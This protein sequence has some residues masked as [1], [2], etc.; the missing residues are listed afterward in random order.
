MDQK[1]VTVDE[2]GPATVDEVGPVP[3]TTISQP[4]PG[5]GRRSRAGAHQDSSLVGEADEMVK[6]PA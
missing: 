4:G 6:P 1:R 3:I 5:D 2:V